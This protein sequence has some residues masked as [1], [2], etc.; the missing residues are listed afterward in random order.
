MSSFFGNAQRLLFVTSSAFG[1]AKHVVR[2]AD[3]WNEPKNIA[4]LISVA[5][6][7]SYSELRSKER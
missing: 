4:H 5:Q 7:S 3:V 2:I 6:Q 1:I